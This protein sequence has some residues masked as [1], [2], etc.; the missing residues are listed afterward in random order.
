MLR[1]MAR[2]HPTDFTVG[3]RERGR[4]RKGINEKNDADG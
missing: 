2:H 3:E 4:E 1:L